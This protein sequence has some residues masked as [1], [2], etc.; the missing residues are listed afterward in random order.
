[1]ATAE[2]R[3]E[4]ALTPLRRVH[5]RDMRERMTRAACNGAQVT[6]EPW[7]RGADGRALREGRL[8]LPSRHD[9]EIDGGG[10]R[11]HPRVETPMEAEFAPFAALG[12]EGFALDIRPFRWE[13]AELTLR[14]THGRPNW[15]PLRLWFL[16]FAHPGRPVDEA[17]LLGVLHAM[18]DPRPVGA[19]ASLRLDFG[20]APICAVTA[21]VGALSRTGASAARLADAEP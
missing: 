17:E 10:R 20:S 18:H 4:E 11:L 21:L 19:G 8:N 12:P 7:R 16:E 13:A 1:M 5:L 9:F 3:L 14:L 2:D 15:A 6:P